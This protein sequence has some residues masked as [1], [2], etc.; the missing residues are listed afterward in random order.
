MPP[1]LTHVAL[2]VQDL[3]RSIAFYERYAALHVCHD[4]NDDGTRV[5]WLSEQPD[6][7]HFVFVLIPMAHADAVQPGVHH[8]GFAMASREEV[9]EMADT[10]RAH[11]VLRD[12][13]KDA[14]PIVGYYCIVEDP[15]GNWVEF[16]HGQS[17]NPRD[18]PREGPQ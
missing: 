16:S 1:Q 17:I 12:G 2:R 10:A 3:E 18:L 7:P 4:R 14:G 8:F 6:D 9:D 13:P 15:D 5:V 11:G